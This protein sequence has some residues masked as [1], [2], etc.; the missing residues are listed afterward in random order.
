[1]PP[2][3]TSIVPKISDPP[4]DAGKKLDKIDEMFEVNAEEQVE[5][6]RTKRV[7]MSAIKRKEATRK[8]AEKEG[9]WTP[10]E[11]TQF[12]DTGVIPI[13]HRAKYD[14]AYDPNQVNPSDV[15]SGVPTKRGKPAKRN[16]RSAQLVFNPLPELDEADSSTAEEAAVGKKKVRPPKAAVPAT[17]ATNKKRKNA[18]EYDN[19]E[20]E[21][22]AQVTVS[23]R[24]RKASSPVK[25][26]QKKDEEP[27]EPARRTTRAAS[28]P[29]PTSAPAPTLKKVGRPKLKAAV[30]SEEDEDESDEEPPPKVSPVKRG[31][32]ASPEK[33]KK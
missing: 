20:E 4:A 25:K 17:P 8:R 12:Y 29:A 5:Y 9:D 19:S 11:F 7:P 23:K 16:A 33:K 14:A 15:D 1:V 21:E 31:R 30:E 24:A 26:K 22:P 27:V 6:N 13:R 10:E 32:K 28:T 2:V 3:I 18:V